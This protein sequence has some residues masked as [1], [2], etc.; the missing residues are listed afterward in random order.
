MGRQLHGKNLSWCCLGEV[1]GSVRPRPRG[2]STGPAGG[3][4]SGFFSHCTVLNFLT[5]YLAAQMR[6]SHDSCLLP[7]LSSLH[8]RCCRSIEKLGAKPRLANGRNQDNGKW[9][10][11]PDP[12]QNGFARLTRM[13]SGR[14]AHGTQREFPC[15]AAQGAAAS[16]G[17][18]LTGSS[19]HGCRKEMLPSLRR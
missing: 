9:L 8:A 7:G 17:R 19:L 18:A 12:V 2:P 15:A 5:M 13:D 16:V 3:P 6:I 4:E 14:D 10:S 1:R 11:F